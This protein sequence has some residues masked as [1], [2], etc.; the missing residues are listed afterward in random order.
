[1]NKNPSAEFTLCSLLPTGYEGLGMISHS[2][3]ATAD[4]QTQSPSEGDYFGL[5]LIVLVSHNF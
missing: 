4:T 1:M 5:L 2:V 3:E